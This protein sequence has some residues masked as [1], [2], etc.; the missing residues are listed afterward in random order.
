[1]RKLINLLILTLILLILV[2]LT[3]RLTQ[4]RQNRIEYQN[5]IAEL[6]QNTTKFDATF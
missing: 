4:R 3:I 6:Y 1:M 2:H 5:E